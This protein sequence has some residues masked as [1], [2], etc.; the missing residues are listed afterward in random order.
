MAASVKRTLKAF[1]RDSMPNMTT[2]QQ[3]HAA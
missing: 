1:G 3:Q 2:T